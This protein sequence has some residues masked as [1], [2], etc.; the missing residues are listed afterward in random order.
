MNVQNKQRVLN[1][2]YIYLIVLVLAA[3]IILVSCD[4]NIVAPDPNPSTVETIETD[5][6]MSY[7][8]EGKAATEVNFKYKPKY[9]G[10]YVFTAAENSLLP[11]LNGVN[12]EDGQI[13]YYDQNK[14]Y[15]FNFKV[16]DPTNYNIVAISM[17]PEKISTSAR[18]EIKRN[19]NYLI[20]CRLSEP[21]LYEFET[22]GCDF[23]IYD[24]RHKEINA[25][26]DNAYFLGSKQLENVFI[27]IE[28]FLYYEDMTV[29]F[30]INKKDLEKI[31][32]D[33]SQPFEPIQIRGEAG[34]V[35]YLELDLQV[36]GQTIYS[37]VFSGRGH[38]SINA[39]LYENIYFKRQ[40][41]LNIEIKDDISKY[42]FINISK[43]KYYLKLSF[44]EEFE[45]EINIY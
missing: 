14:E 30:E 12:V 33:K 10:R 40:G 25:V 29:D 35:R 42:K 36:V 8:F 43:G 3:T 38:K 27:V 39:E 28:R 23:K 16:T 24:T 6:N 2:T 18:L 41:T 9:S 26:G 4:K 22:G 32:V 1:L 13:D 20:W 11:T 7:L 5:Y 45:G 15:L 44:I 37:I 31:T 21:A 17:Y 34:E 19:T